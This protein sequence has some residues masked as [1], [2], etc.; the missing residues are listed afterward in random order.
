VD[1]ADIPVTRLKGVGPRKA[2]ALE[3]V[4]VTNV[5]DLLTYYPRRYVDRTRQAAIGDLALGEEATVVAEVVRSTSQRTK[6]GGSMAQVDVDDGSGRLR[7]TFFNQ[8][9]RERQ[10][11]PGRIVVVYGRLDEFRGRRQMA[12]PVVDLIGDRTA[13]IV[14][15]YPQ[16]EKAGLTTWEIGDWVAEALRRTQVRGVA[17]PVPGE[18]LARWEL[19]DRQRALELIHAP[20]TMAGAEVGRRRSSPRPSPAPSPC[21]DR[22]P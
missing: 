7:L 13:R 9:W 4:G 5:A 18:V 11:Q 8:A 20:D 1:L 17:D 3:A 2:R 10:L 14:P 21:G 19:T 6:R 16:S 22:R 12:N 15:I